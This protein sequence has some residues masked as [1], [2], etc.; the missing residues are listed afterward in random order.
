M[1]LPALCCATLSLPGPWP[2][3]NGRLLNWLVPLGCI[4]LAVFPPPTLSKLRDF[5]LGSPRAVYE[6]P[7]MPLRDRCGLIW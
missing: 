5:S 4:L 1:V 7:P 3:A 6:L 2:N